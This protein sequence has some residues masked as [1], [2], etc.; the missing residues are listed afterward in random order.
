MQLKASNA[1]RRSKRLLNI[2]NDSDAYIADGRWDYARR[3]PQVAG[4]ALRPAKL[5]GKER[6]IDLTPLLSE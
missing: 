5:M 6:E 3:A 4:P 1:R 2:G